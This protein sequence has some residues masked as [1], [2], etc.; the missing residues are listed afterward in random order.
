[1]A[2]KAEIFLNRLDEITQRYFVNRGRANRI[3]RTNGW[4]ISKQQR[5]GTDRVYDV[6]RKSNGYFLGHYEPGKLYIIHE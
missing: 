5:P 6:F 3:C 4:C 1:M 2:L